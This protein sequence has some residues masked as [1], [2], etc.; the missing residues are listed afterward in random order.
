MCTMKISSVLAVALLGFVT[1]ARAQE[2]TTVNVP[3]SFVVGH[4]TFPAGPY[5]LRTP[6]S[7]PA[8]FA[9]QGTKNAAFSFV[10]THPAGGHDPSGN[11]PA[12]VFTRYENGYRLWQI[13]E[14]DNQGYELFGIS[15]AAK[16]ARAEEQVDLSRLSTRVVPA[17]LN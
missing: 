9:L 3:F 15:G 2:L 8:V 5:E 13:W 17:T 4:E 7:A 6:D 14:S 10:A 12:L 1:S 16:V 11:E